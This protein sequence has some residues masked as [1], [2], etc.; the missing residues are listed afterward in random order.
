MLKFQ[1]AIT[2][3]NSTK[4][5]ANPQL[6]RLVL[7]KNH[8]YLDLTLAMIEDFKK[9]FFC[10]QMTSYFMHDIQLI[11]FSF[12]LPSKVL[13]K[14]NP[15]LKTDWQS[16]QNPMYIFLEELRAGNNLLCFFTQW[17]YQVE[18][19][20]LAIQIQNPILILDCQSQSNPPNWIAIQ[21]EISNPAIPW[22]YLI[23][24]LR[25]KVKQIS[26]IYF[27]YCKLCRITCHL[28]CRFDIIITLTINLTSFA[29]KKS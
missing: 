21:I 2:H 25:I 13:L 3:W 15:L 24:Y 29:K 5:G 17:K 23:K 19:F 12:L 10:W 20:L 7:N 28:N 11:L 22:W 14:S 9:V 27:K 1:N 4:F 16:Y 26:F 8:E 6:R 18:I